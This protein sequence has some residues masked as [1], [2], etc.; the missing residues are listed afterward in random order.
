M[1]EKFNEATPLR[2][3]GD[4]M[5]DAW[6]VTID[7]PSSLEQIRKEK[8]WK[9]SDRNAITIFKTNGMTIVLIALHRGAEMVKHVAE[10]LLT[11]QMIEGSI[12]FNTKNQSLQ[13]S[14]GQIIAL[15]EGI[16][17]SLMAE[18]ESVF[19][20]TLTN[21]ATPKHYKG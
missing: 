21:V 6:L 17:H 11:I 4:R 14:K 3:K 19:L 16:S 10:G 15:H 13:I 9:E 20:L 1:V 7:L 8:T 5:M 2:P 12:L 18:E